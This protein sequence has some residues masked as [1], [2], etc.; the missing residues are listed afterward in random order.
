MERIVGI[1]DPSVRCRQAIDMYL[2]SIGPWFSASEVG[3]IHGS[4]GS[5]RYKSTG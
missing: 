1:E 4:N 5:K 2:S 3:V